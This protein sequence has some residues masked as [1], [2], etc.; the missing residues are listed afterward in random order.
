MLPLE[1]LAILGRRRG[2][3]GGVE[4]RCTGQYAGH[5]ALPRGGGVGT[6]GDIEAPGGTQY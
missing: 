2:V 4:L 6:R 3:T 5:E 1:G